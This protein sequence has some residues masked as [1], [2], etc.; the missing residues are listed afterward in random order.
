MIIGSKIFYKEKIYNSLDWAKENIEN[1]LDGS[2]FL[3][4]I[5]EYTK[6][7]DNRTWIFNQDQLTLTILLKPNNLNKIE[8][9]ELPLR[10]NQLNMA[11]ILGILKPLHK[12]K[13][14]LKWPNDLYYQSKKL[15]G[16]LSQVIW[17]NNKITGIIIGFALNINKT[18]KLNTNW[19]K[20]ISIKD[21]SGTTI[22]KNELLNEILKSINNYYGEWL[23]LNFEK[24]FSD[25]KSN[26]NYLNKTVT[27][28]T[29]NNE[30]LSGIF[31][32]VL[33]NGDLKL[34]KESE[35]IQIP[36]HTIE[37]LF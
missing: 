12:F 18:P 9:K 31:L 33:E 7:R 25:W 14:E 19:Y 30:H 37:S 2:I 34:K 6:G 22:D 8:K 26:Q 28:H 15:G 24:I 10:L 20:A 4:D 3:A 36:F 11:I 17:K 35:I 23:N 27:V 13:I 5:H 29:K 16:M 1:A 32:D 21:I